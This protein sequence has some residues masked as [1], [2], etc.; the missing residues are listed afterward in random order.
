M[1]HM[2]AFCARLQEGRA[3]EMGETVTLQAVAL[4]TKHTGLSRGCDPQ[5][6]ERRL[7]LLSLIL[8]GQQVERAI[9]WND[10]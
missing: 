10:F 6:S 2:A 8:N 5:D 9:G 3:T 7:I 1:E 4:P